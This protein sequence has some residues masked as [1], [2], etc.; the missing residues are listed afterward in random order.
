MNAYGIENELT[1]QLMDGLVLHIPFSFQHCEYT[2]FSTLYTNP[3]TNV[4]TTVD[5]SGLPVNR[6]PDVTATVDLSYSFATPWT[7]GRIVVDVNDNYVSKNLDTYSITPYFNQSFTQT[8]ADARA[9]LGASITYN[10]K[11]D[12]WFARLYGRNLL[13]RIYKESGQNVDPLWVWAFYGEPQFFGG[14]IGFKFGQPK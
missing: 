2:K 6:C 7:P 9:L 4:T 3:V 5:L 12:R 10:G 11:D 1:A 14:E 8:Y 13:N